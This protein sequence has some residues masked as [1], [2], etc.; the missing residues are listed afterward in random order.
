MIQYVVEF[1]GQS[2]VM[3]IET[4]GTLEAKTHFSALLEKVQQGEI[5]HITKH[6]KIIAELKPLTEKAKK[7]K[8]GFAKDTFGETSPDFDAPLDDFSDYMK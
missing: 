2:R 7:R 4:I 6:G 3:K 8:A 5:Y 1:C